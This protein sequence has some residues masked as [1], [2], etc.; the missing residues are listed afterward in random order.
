MRNIHDPNEFHKFKS[1]TSGSNN[2][3]GSGGKGP[4]GAGYC[5]RYFR[6]WSNRTALRNNSNS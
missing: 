4:S 5:S 3:G 2:S 6:L 1:T